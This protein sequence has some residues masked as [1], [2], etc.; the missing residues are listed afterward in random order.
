[1]NILLAHN[2]YLQPGGEDECVA[3]EAAMLKANGHNVIRYDVHNE[4]TATM[5]YFNLAARTLW[6]KVAYRDLTELFRIH[7]PQIA[8]FHNIF[9]LI[10]PSAYY[11]ARRQSVRVVQTVHNFRL[12]CA[13]A[14]LYRDGFVCED[15]LGR[16]V[17]WSGLAR[18]CYRGSFAASGGITAMTAVHRAM[19]T[20][21]RSVDM[22][23]AL[24]EFAR[25]KLIEGGLPAERIAVKS[26]F[27]HPDSGPGPGRGGYGLFVGRL[28]VEKGLETLIGAW[29]Q[30]RS[31]VPLK[32]VGDGPLSGVVRAAC[33][34]NPLIEWLGRQPRDEVDRLMGDAAVL[35]QPSQ[36]YETF[37][38]VI[39]EGYARGI[40]VIASRHGAMAELVSDGRTGFLFTPGDAGDRAT[41]RVRPRCF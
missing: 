11:A 3:A 20:W 28:S 14:L 7:R 26:N 5:P 21:A 1:M 41:S 22:Y 37:G 4:E 6:S 19:G 40:P 38:R 9:P 13:N 34:R 32:I 30:L 36:C 23:I 16:S 35:I 24:T 15:C 8:H 33:A 27:V 17:G 18:R 39:V 2:F 12:L 25:L 10:S 29:R 31:P